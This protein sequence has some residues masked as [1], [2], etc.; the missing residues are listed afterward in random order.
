MDMLGWD[1]INLGGI[2]KSVTAITN[3]AKVIAPSAA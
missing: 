2:E 3:F 1:T